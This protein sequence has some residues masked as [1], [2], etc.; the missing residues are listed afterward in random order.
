LGAAV[1]HFAFLNGTMSKS[2]CEHLT[3][4]FHEVSSR[5]DVKMIVLVGGKSAWSNGINLNKIEASSDAAKDI[6]T[7]NDFVKAIFST[8]KITIAALQGNA[9]ADGAMAALACNYIW[10]HEKAILNPHYKSMGLHGSKYLTHF[11]LKCIGD[12]IADQLT[13]TC[14]PVSARMA[15]ALG[16]IDDILTHDQASFMDLVHIY[17]DAVARNEPL[18]QVMKSK[19]MEQCTDDWFKHLEFICSHELLIMHVNFTTNNEYI[20][21][22]KNFV[23][24]KNPTTIPV[25]LTLDQYCP[26]ILNTKKDVGPCTKSFSKAFKMNGSKVANIILEASNQE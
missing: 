12:E 13:E 20:Q 11:L 18:V 2:Q 9:G 17:S 22:H 24:K 8:N 15:K 19:K 23:Y 10:T 6:N 21:A 1:I 3:S 14:M 5:D 4:F 25:H 7:I 26:H 16:M